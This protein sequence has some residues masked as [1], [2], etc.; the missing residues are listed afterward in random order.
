MSKKIFRSLLWVLSVLVILAVLLAAVGVFLTRSHIPNRVARR[1]F[2]QVEGEIHIPGLDG[3]V[4]VYR[5]GMGIP[6]IYATTLHDLFVAQGYV[7]AQERFWQMDFWRH[8]GSGRLAEMFGQSQVETDTFLRTLGWRKVA[9]QELEVYDQDFLDILNDYTEGVNAYLADRSGTDLSLEYGVLKLLNPDYKPEPWQ[10][11][12]SLTWGKAMAWDLRG[13]IDEEIERAILLKTLTAEQVDE[14]FPPYPADHP[15]IVPA[16]GENVS[17]DQ[18]SPITADWSLPVPVSQL[19]T[20]S[21]HL[22]ALDSFLGPAGAGIGSN[23]WAVTGERTAT[24]MPLLANDPHLGI[25]MPSIWFQIGLHCRP[26]TTE[27]PFEM[28]G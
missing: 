20:V 13:N 22:A 2:P 25:Q 15:V 28:A 1:S 9:E 4:D 12:H 24:G 21:D 10:P 16:I 26:Q 5:D 19:D 7:H 6:H 14:L 3:A 18:W 8:M 27:C 11:V 17:A 23:S